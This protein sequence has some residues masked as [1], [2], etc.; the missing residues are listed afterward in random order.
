MRGCTQSCPSVPMVLPTVSYLH[1]GLH[2]CSFRFL[3]LSFQGGRGGEL[4]PLSPYTPGV[5]GAS[6][7]ALRAV[8][9]PP[10]CPRRPGTQLHA[11]ES[12][13]LRPILEVWLM[14]KWLPSP[15]NP[16]PCPCS[17]G[18]GSLLPR[19]ARRVVRDSVFD[20]DHACQAFSAEV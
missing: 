10:P 4:H 5:P 8:L 13:Q 6:P 9:A 15:S 2:P 16:R 3:C 20:S 1:A 14:Y 17:A 19:I 12:F 7:V 11:V 18:G